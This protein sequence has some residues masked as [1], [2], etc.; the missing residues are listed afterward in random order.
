MKRHTLALAALMLLTV[1]AKAQH[2]SFADAPLGA[3]PKDFEFALTGSG[4]PG[5]WTVVEDATAESGR[6]LA[7]VNADPTDYRFPLAIYMPTLPSDVEV[8]TRFKPISGKIDRSGVSSS[9]SSTAT[10]TT[11]PG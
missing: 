1:P 4:K 9:D 5:E 8:T 7:Q 10:I 2:V 3:K 6:A 11:S